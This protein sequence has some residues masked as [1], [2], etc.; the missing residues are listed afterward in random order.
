MAE[1]KPKAAD[2]EPT[3]PLTSQTKAGDSATPPT[4]K[5]ATPPT[6]APE[7]EPV[8]KPASE[9][10]K[11]LTSQTAAAPLEPPLERPVKTNVAAPPSLPNAA[12]PQVFAKDD[13]IRLYDDHGNDV[14]V[15]D[16]FEYPSAD[17]PGTLAM[18]KTRVYREYTP[19]GAKTQV[20]Q[21]LYPAGALV[22]IFEA[23]RVKT[24][25]RHAGPAQQ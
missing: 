6:V 19:M 23:E 21:L 2:G 1:R 18:V 24:E 12:T 4:V 9:P 20:R 25:N 3:K 7:S 8:V 14:S 10:V 16:L 5:P 13:S 15:D 17:R 22:S 11:P